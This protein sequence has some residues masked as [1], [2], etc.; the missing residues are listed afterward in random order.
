MRSGISP[1]ESRIQILY[2]PIKYFNNYFSAIF[3]HKLVCLEGFY[4]LCMLC[5]LHT[6]NINPINSFWLLNLGCFSYYVQQVGTGVTYLCGV[7]LWL[8]V[9]LTPQIYF[10]NNTFYHLEFILLALIL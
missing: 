2:F 3:S 1:Q 6:M 7:I 5:K 8:K 9:I 10:V 4:I